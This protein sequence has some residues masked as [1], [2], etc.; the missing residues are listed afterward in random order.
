MSMRLSDSLNISR[1]SLKDAQKKMGIV[2]RNLS[3]A[4]DPNYSHRTMISHLRSDGSCYTTISRDADEGLL[5]DY[6]LKRSKAYGASVFAEGVSKLDAIYNSDE[7]SHSPFAGIEKLKESLQFYVNQSDKTSA[8]KG[9]LENAGNLARGLNAASEQIQKLRENANTSIAHDVEEVNG[10]LQKLQTIEKHLL[11]NKTEDA[12]HYMD[13]RDAVLKELSGHM[14]ITYTKHDDGSIVVHAAGGVTLFDKDPRKVTFTPS[15]LVPGKPGGA[16][17]VDGVPLTHNSFV[18]PHGDGSLG[19]L[20][21]LRDET[22]VQYQNQLDIMASNLIDLFKHAGSQKQALFQ[23][24]AAKPPAGKAATIHLNPAFNLGGT[25][26]LADANEMQKIIDGFTKQ[27]LNYYGYD[28]IKIGLRLQDKASLSSFA[29][30]SLAW[31][32]DLVKS[33]KADN[34]YNSTMFQHTDQMLSNA[35]GVNKDGEY[36]MIID[37]EQSYSAS[38][39][40]MAAVG[41]MMDDLLAA[42]R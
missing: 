4:D 3:G 37:I 40:L 22:C 19:N 32:G 36:S 15:T 41:K 38:A 9:F 11:N 5:A 1:N 27:P 10:L 34:E 21:K 18:N 35:V 8:A 12:Y 7:F 30:D 16:I 26:K 23:S 17:N 29:K 6:L 33:S 28:A 13:Q 39:K 42:V 2:S 20:L 25:A 24:D 31:M 14:A